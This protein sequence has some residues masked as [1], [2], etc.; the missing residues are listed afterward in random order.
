MDKWEKEESE[1]RESRER[2]SWTLADVK[3]SYQRAISQE[4][5][6]REFLLLKDIFHVS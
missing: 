3:L 5:K 6:F 1:V 4:G 2:V